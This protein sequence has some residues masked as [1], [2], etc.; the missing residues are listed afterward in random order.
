MSEIWSKNVEWY[1]CKVS[2]ILVRFLW[3][4]N[5]LGRFFEKYLNVK[6]H[7][8]PSRGN[9]VVTREQA[10]GRTGI[11][12][13]TVAFRNSAN[14]PKDYFSYQCYKFLYSWMA[15]CRMHSS[16]ISRKWGVCVPCYSA[17]HTRIHIPIVL[18]TVPLQVRQCRIPCKDV[19]D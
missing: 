19:Y 4:W 6:F 7:E 10:D 1:S 18:R 2:F 12:K 8:N 15:S 13:L 16:Q 3:N 5:F 11:T 9:R 17:S 14:A